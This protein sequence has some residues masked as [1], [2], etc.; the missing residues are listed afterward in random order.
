MFLDPGKDYCK[1]CCCCDLDIKVGDIVKP[2][3]Y[4]S[5][6]IYRVIAIHNNEMWV[7]F[8]DTYRAWSKSGIVCKDGYV[9]VMC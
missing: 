4:R 7:S 6:L 1:R 5:D 2:K 9:K 3:H 8:T